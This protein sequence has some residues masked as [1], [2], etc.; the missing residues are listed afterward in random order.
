MF[1]FGFLRRHFDCV[2][3]VFQE[4][5]VRGD[6]ARAVRTFRRQTKDGAALQL[7]SRPFLN[8]RKLG[9]AISR[10]VAFIGM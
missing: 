4:P 7:D 1:D 6:D 5:L 9:V 10:P 3:I 8:H 2:V